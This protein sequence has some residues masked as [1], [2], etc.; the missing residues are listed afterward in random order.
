MSVKNNLMGKNKKNILLVA[1]YKSDVGYAWWLMEN[2]WATIAGSFDACGRK[3]VLLYP[4]VNVVPEKIVKA[5]IKVIEHDLSNRSFKSL[6][7]LYR[8]INENDIGYVYLTDRPYCDWLYLILR[9]FGIKK[10]VNHDHL[11][12]ERS[13]LKAIKNFIKSILHRFKFMSCD[14]Y[15]GVSEFIKKRFVEVAGIPEKKCEFV[16]N[17]IRIFDNEKTDYVNRMFGI[18][19]GATIIVSTG[20]AVFYKGIDTLIDVAGEM[21]RKKNREHVYFLYVGDGSDI[22]TFKTMVVERGLSSRF[23]FAGYRRDVSRILPSCDIGIQ[24][25]HGEAFSLSLIE[26]LCAGLVTLAPRHCGNGEAIDDG[27]NGLLFTPGDVAEIVEKIAFVLDH[28]EEARR[29]AGEA[30]RTAVEKFSLEA[31]NE[32]FIALLRQQFI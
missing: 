11:P 9:V 32:R 12:G 24:V 6:S 27:R 22:D 15:I 1:N 25:S 13:H 23:I 17:G 8:I 19:E 14:Y 21:A 29:L 2:F 28:E 4:E 5:K 20:R 30:R 31:C 7:C 26:Y 3:A 16:H 18:P 10:I